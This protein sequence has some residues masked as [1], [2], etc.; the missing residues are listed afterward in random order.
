MIIDSFKIKSTDAVCP[1][2]AIAAFETAD[3]RENTCVLSAV[4]S[5]P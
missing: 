3:L 5:S 1:N 4:A 2:A